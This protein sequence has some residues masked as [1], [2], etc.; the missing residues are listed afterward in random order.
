MSEYDPKKIRIL[1]DAD[2]NEWFDDEE[3]THKPNDTLYI[4]ADWI[5]EYL[6]EQGHQITVSI[7]DK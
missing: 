6:I 1:K 4:R 2:T 7:K 5:W 3:F